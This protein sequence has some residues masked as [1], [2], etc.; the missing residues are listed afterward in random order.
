MRIILL[1]FT[2][3]MFLLLGGCPAININDMDRELVDLYRLKLTTEN[4][5]GPF[6]LAE[7]TG[8][9]FTDLAEKAESA[10]AKLT[11]RDDLLNRVSLL[12]IAMMARWQAYGRSGVVQNAAGAGSP[13]SAAPT[14]ESVAG[15]GQDACKVRDDQGRLVS[16]RLPR[17]CALFHIAPVVA[18]QD[19]NSRALA[20]LAPSDPADAFRRLRNHYSGALTA[21]DSNA[22][23]RGKPGD[24]PVPPEFWSWVD[25][26]RL[27]AYC[28]MEFV[29]DKARNLDNLPEA[30]PESR[31]C[32]N[33]TT[34]AMNSLNRA[35]RQG[36]LARLFG[37]IDCSSVR[38]KPPLWTG[39]AFSAA[40]HEAVKFFELQNCRARP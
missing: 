37:E 6:G 26:Q 24:L 18:K 20:A 19:I 13:P 21:Y 1:L 15:S 3:P 30:G 5:Q 7:T 38:N 16:Q 31:I 32:R 2:L 12:R 10:A 23:F 28:D 34:T 35:L 39:A 17:D 29:L 4:E 9:R 36:D 40:P 8:V 14:F 25:R 27:F 22:E 11:G 33:E